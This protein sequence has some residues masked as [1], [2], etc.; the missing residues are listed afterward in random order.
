M[1][2][3]KEMY[4]YT[5]NESPF[6]VSTYIVQANEPKKSSQLIAKAEIW[7]TLSYYTLLMNVLQLFRSVLLVR[8]LHPL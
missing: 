6:L 2:N 4:V 7:Y 3:L 8:S 1:Q 5:F